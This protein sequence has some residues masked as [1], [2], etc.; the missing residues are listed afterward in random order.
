[1]GPRSPRGR[2]DSGLRDRMHAGQRVGGRLPVPCPIRDVRPNRLIRHSRVVSSQASH[3]GDTRADYP[4]GVSEPAAPRRPDVTGLELVGG[5]EKRALVLVEHDPAWA[6]RYADLARRIR[7]AVG[8]AAVAVEHIGSTSVPGL[9]AKPIVDVLVTVPD[10]TAEEDYLEPL[11]AAGFPL[12]VREPGH[13]MV[14]TPERDANI[15]VV[16]V[17][18]QAAED[19]LVLRDHLRVDAEDRQLYEDTKRAL[20]QR[21]WP[22]TNAYAD[23][24]TEVVEAIKARARVRTRTG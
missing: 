8:Q 13:R 3:L 5:I 12:R 23:A 16:E 15:H 7:E 1:M 17:G 2:A 19:Y 18:A 20:V 10:I 11:V 24:K 4:A 6:E 22:D 14:R 9:A 21:D